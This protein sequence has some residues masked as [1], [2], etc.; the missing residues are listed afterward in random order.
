MSQTLSEIIKQAPALTGCYLFRGEKNQVLYVGK[1]KNLYKRLSTY[2]RPLGD[3]R[4]QIPAML[5]SAQGLEYL[6]TSNE[7]EALILEN[8]LIKFHKPPYNIMLRDDKSYVSIRIDM[9]HPYPRPRVVHKNRKDKA[10][11]LGPFVS[12]KNLRQTLEALKY[13]FPL[14][15]CSD[16][17]FRNRKRVCVYYDI[18]VCAGPCVQ[19]KI[20]QESYQTALQDFIK[21]FSGQNQSVI[22]EYEKNMQAAAQAENFEKAA[23]YRDQLFALRSTLQTQSTE[24]GKKSWL[25]H[26]VIGFSREEDKACLYLLL[27][28]DGQLLTSRVYYF[29][30]SLSNDELIE[31]FVSRY[32]EK[33]NQFP[34]EL[35]LPCEIDD[36]LALSEYLSD[37]AGFAVKV[38]TPQ[39]GKKKEL[40]GLANLN[41]QH[42]IK[43]HADK[44]HKNESLLYSLQKNLQ[45][46]NLPRIIECYD[47]SHFQGSETVASG[48]CFVNG[49]PEKKRYRRYKIQTTE[50]GDDFAAME[51]VLRRRI[52]KGIEEGN[53]PDV[54]ILDGGP[55]QL[56]RVQTVFSELNVIGIDLLAL[57]KS[58][59]KSKGYSQP[60]GSYTARQKTLER[61]FRADQEQPFILNQ[62][63]PELFLLM[64]IRDEAHRVAINY[65]R[66]RIRKGA[67]HSGLDRIPGVGPRRKRALLKHF[68][69]PAVI[70]SKT[71]DEIA[72]L[73]GISLKLAEKIQYELQ[74]KYPQK[75][76]EK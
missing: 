21:V 44:E 67:L 68:G 47:I 56:N 43:N 12:A 71:P 7:K 73:P 30:F 50:I 46:E 52:K 15:R 20:S 53:F 32:Y 2:L 69:S 74:K 13:A 5:R 64:R 36:E 27:Y 65:N 31:Q 25:H 62:K 18:G 66:E 39:R 48:V 45:L 75:K 14:R 11:Y 70:A 4:F 22:A 38:L 24:L 17:V 34:H 26:D 40:V 42:A 63:S 16:H 3:G 58:R 33:N 72:S 55:L 19:G 29:D 61:I 35:L 23:F 6:L 41:A 57:A 8:N 51:E 60:Y 28:R 76:D 49:L 9:N 1:A 54:I 10:F 37:K 59:D